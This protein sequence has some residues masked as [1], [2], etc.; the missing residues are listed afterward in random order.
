MW[1]MA[2]NS[3]KN[4]EI[5]LCQ[6][7]QLPVLHISP[8][9]SRDSFNFMTCDLCRKTLVNALVQKHF[10]ESQSRQHTVRGFF[11]KGDDLL[12]LYRWKTLQKIPQ[13]FPALHVV[14]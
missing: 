10:H 2:V 3:H 8:T 13:G 4:I 11:Q 5:H 14:Q 7:Q 6:C 12:S 1:Q 9:H